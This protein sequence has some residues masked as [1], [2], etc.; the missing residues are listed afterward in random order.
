MQKKI[1]D[2][3]PKWIFTKQDRNLTLTND[4]DSLLSC[5]LLKYLF[6]YN[7]NYFYSFDFMAVLDSSDKRSS[8]GVDLALKNG[9]TLCNHLTLKHI[10]SYKNPDSVNLNNILGISN[11]NYSQKYSGS[12]LLMLWSIFDLPLPKSEEGKKILLS[13]DSA[14]KGYR[15]PQYRHILVNWLDRLGL[16]ELIPTLE[17]NPFNEMEAFRFKHELDTSINFNMDRELQFFPSGRNKSSDGG[18]DLEWISKH[19]G[20]QVEL[21]KEQF[22]FELKATFT[23]ENIEAHEMTQKTIDKSFSYAFTYKN[24][25]KLSTIKGVA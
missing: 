7:I 6:G 21:P 3:L 18:L 1:K 19:L 8:I 25:L 24:K 16:T 4:L 13:I 12:T 10:N 23:N 15:K 20:F 17:D 9:Y 2:L 14:H 22:E 11:D 5:M